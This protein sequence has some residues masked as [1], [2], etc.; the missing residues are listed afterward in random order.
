MP[1]Q[2]VYFISSNHERSLIAESWASRLSTKDIVFRS[3]GWSNAK[4]SPYSIEAMK[5][6]SIDITTIKPN[7]L[8]KKELEKADLI[9]VI[10]D[11]E[12]D[13]EIIF[14]SGFS[15]KLLLWDIINPEKR[16]TDYDEKW[17]MFQ[18][19]CDDIA[20]RVQ[21]LGENYTSL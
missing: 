8:N 10:Q 18:E 4:A 2:I 3:G 16:S 9:V 21:D 17:L 1:S 20:L 5:E 11:V 12:N 6:I 13:E 15:D 14:S 7:I 19:I